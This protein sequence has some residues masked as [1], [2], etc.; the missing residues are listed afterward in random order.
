[1][2]AIQFS[3]CQKVDEYTY[4]GRTYLLHPIIKLNGHVKRC[5]SQLTITKINQRVGLGEDQLDQIL[6]IRIE[7]P[8]FQSWDAS[9]TVKL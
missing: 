6:R 1:M 7:G 8:P 5:F 9:N 2:E 3:L 4:L